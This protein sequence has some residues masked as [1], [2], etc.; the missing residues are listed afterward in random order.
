[1]KFRH[2]L[3]ILLV[4]T[5]GNC[6]AQ[7]DMY[8][9]YDAYCQRIRV[10]PTLNSYAS[11]LNEA[12]KFG[13]SFVRDT[14]PNKLDTE[15]HLIALVVAKR[16][17]AMFSNKDWQTKNRVS[18][19]L[20]SWVSTCAYELRETPM[21]SAFDSTQSQI[22]KSDLIKQQ[23]T[24]ERNKNSAGFAKPNGTIE[25]PAST[26]NRF[27]A[28]HIERKPLPLDEPLTDLYAINYPIF[29]T[30]LFTD[31]EQLLANTA[32]PT[33][34][35]IRAQI[36]FRSKL[37]HDAIL[38]KEEVER[39]RQSKLALEASERLKREAELKAKEEEEAAV[40]RYRQRLGAQGLLIN[41]LSLFVILA[42]GS[43]VFKRPILDHL[44]RKG[45]V[46]N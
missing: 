10:N 23:N 1:M 25:S 42:T 18:S 30:L 28:Q 22:L 3:I 33:L 16:F 13:P 34:E 26:S 31:G 19:T 11:L 20:L 9:N 38:A 37:D 17:E 43:Y 36:A 41:L 40:S 7:T 45:W 12:S 15:D 46:K 27:F 32:N 8:D 4:W 35:K 24:Y 44:Q 2:L 29:L 14:D 39:E 6:F 5:A 21:Y